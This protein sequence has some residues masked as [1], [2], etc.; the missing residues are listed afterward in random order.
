M[1]KWVSHVL[2]VSGKKFEKHILKTHSLLNFLDNLSIY[3]R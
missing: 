2:N 1:P 3:Y